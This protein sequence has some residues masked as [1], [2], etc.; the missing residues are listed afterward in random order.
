MTSGSLS[1]EAANSRN[2][3]ER[4]TIALMNDHWQSFV[5][6]VPWFIQ[7]AER[8]V[9]GP[10][11]PAG[12]WRLPVRLEVV[13]PRL[14][15]LLAHAHTSNVS[16]G[17]RDYVLFSWETHDG[18]TTW[19]SPRP[20]PSS[21]VDLLPAHS[22]LLEVFG[23]I[24]E[25][26]QEPESTWLLNTNESLTADEASHDASFIKAAE[27][28]WAEVPGGIPIDTTAYYSISREANGNTTLCHRRSGE[29]LLFAQ[30]HSF[31]DV[32]VLEGCPPYTLYRRRGGR[33]FV[34]WVETV[35][36]QWMSAID[37]PP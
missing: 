9:V 25:R 18:I 5:D 31:D 16:V 11:R 22:S 37:A 34:E 35:A 36:E 20:S 28:V 23:G 21:R 2:I 6:D 29:V 15:A 19:L 1:H 4:Q 8:A 26:S 33:T 17:R 30:D 10:L 14:A 27:G 24:V 12:D 32:D 13:F 7:P 3:P